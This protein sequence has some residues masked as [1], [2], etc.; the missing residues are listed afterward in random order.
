MLCAQQLA[1]RVWR[2][3]KSRRAMD[4]YLSS[5]VFKPAAAQYLRQHTYSKNEQT[6]TVN[7]LPMAPVP[8]C[9]APRARPAPRARAK[10][11]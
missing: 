1:S 6:D 11:L 2:G 8:V 5:V 3:T 7:I 4:R 9:G 10:L